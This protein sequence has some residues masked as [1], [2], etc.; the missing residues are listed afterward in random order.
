MDKQRLLQRGGAQQN[1][2]TPLHGLLSEEDPQATSCHSP[3]PQN[4]RCLEEKGLH[5][6][7][8]P[9]S[10]SFLA[11]PQALP[12]MRAAVCAE[13]LGPARVRV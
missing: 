2:L 8:T 13:H 1:Q 4:P 9:P 10:G 5:M 11:F 3:F 7:L 12:T 6:A